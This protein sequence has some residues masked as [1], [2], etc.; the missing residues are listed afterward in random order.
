MGD[1]GCRIFPH[2]NGEISLKNLTYLPFLH[3]VTPP[4]VWTLSMMPFNKS[5]LCL[6]N[7]M[8]S[9]GKKSRTCNVGASTA[10]H[11]RAVREEHSGGQKPRDAAN[12]IKLEEN[13]QYCNRLERR[14]LLHAKSTVSFLLARGT[15]VTGTVLSGMDFCDFICAQYKLAPPTSRKMWWLFSIILRTS[16]TWLKKCRTCHPTSQWSVWQA[17]PS[18]ETCPFT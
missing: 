17:H 7:T 14:N 12:K 11:V 10:D 18:H 13:V 9:K 6:Q 1:K 2:G 16:H 5:V 8:M 3:K 15:T 4:I